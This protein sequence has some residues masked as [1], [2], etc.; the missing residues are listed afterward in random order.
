MTTVPPQES[1]LVKIQHGELYN[2]IVRCQNLIEN[3]TKA[4]G[5]VEF[6]RAPFGD[7][8][9][10]VIGKYSDL[11]LQHVRWDIDPER[12]AGGS[13]TNLKENI[14]NQMGSYLGGGEKK[15]MVVLFHDVQSVIAY[16]LTS[17]IDEIDRVARAEGYTPDFHLSKEE[18]KSTLRE[19]SKE[20]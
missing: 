15:Q 20:N 13:L 10:G 4:Y 18:L 1:R 7:T 9:D 3:E 16:N 14:T 12:G 5:E 8:N 6:I 19:Q 11:A 17:L 2:D